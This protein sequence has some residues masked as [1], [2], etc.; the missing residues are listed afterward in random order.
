MNDSREYRFPYLIRTAADFPEDFPRF[1]DGTLFPGLFLPRDDPDWFGRSANPPRVILLNNDVLDVHFHPSCERPS[2]SIPFDER[3]SVQIGRLLLIGWIRL[4]SYGTDI[5][6]PYKRRTDEPVRI[7][8]GMLRARLLRP[9]GN[10]GTECMRLGDALDLKFRN[11]LNE[12]IDKEEIGMVRLFIAPQ[13]LPGGWFFRGNRST[14]GCL[15][16]LSDRRLTWITECY[17][18]IRQ[19]Y[20]AL[21]TWAHAD[22]VAH[23]FLDTEGSECRLS[24][25][26]RNGKVWKIGIPAERSADAR[27]FAAISRRLLSSWMA[28]VGAPR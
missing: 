1:P 18:G 6:L 12:E 2:V 3:L 5:K 10:G 14:A 8:L 22:N 21:V 16:N 24:V 27:E 7:F 13:K 28:G 17:G 11:E 15:L 19:R 23:V 26:L 25:M 4:A 9:H 20:G